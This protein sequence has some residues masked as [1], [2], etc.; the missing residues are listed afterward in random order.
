M[1]KAK[2]NL[3]YRYSVTY[4]LQ[5]CY[6]PDSVSGPYVGST[7]RE[8]AGLIRDQLSMFDMPASRIREISINRVWAFIKHHG[9]STAH[10]HIADGEHNVLSFNGLTEQEATEMEASND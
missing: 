10:F 3:P 9:S 7:R 8:L 1:A 6:M 4:G 2:R 5:G